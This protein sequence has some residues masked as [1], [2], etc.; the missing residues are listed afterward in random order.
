MTIGPDPRIRILWM[1]SLRGTD[2]LQE[3]VELVE[4]VVRAGPGLGVVLHRRAVDLE[5]LEALDRAVVEVDVCQRGLP[6]VGLPA[7]GLV[8][9]DAAAA[10]GRLDR[11]AV[12]LRGDLDLLSPQVLDG[13][14]AAAMSERQL[15]GLQADGLAEQLVAEA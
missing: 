13:V 3:A 15:V 6:E 12:I 10:V 2:G 11:E 7:H 4:G 14:V 1:S 9:L 8:G 5:Q